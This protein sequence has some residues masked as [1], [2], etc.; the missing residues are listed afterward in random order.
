M[1][2]EPTD[3]RIGFG[4]FP[5]ALTEKLVEIGDGWTLVV[6]HDMLMKTT[7]GDGVTRYVSVLDLIQNASPNQGQTIIASATEPDSPTEGMIWLDIS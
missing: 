1:R 4:C 5:A 7:D 6:N 2:W 3:N